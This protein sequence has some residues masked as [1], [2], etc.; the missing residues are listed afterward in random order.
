VTCPPSFDE[1]IKLHKQG[2]KFIAGV[3][4]VGRGALAGPV[5]AAAVILPVPANFS[6]LS[7]VRDSKQISPLKRQTVSRL[8][9]KSEIAI[10]LGMISSTIIDGEGIVKATQLAMSQA[11]KKLPLTPDFILIDAIRLPGVPLPQK[12]I[13]HGDR[14][15]LSIACASIIAK[16][17]R[18][19]YMMRQDTLYPVYGLAGHK[20]YG[21][22]EH[23][24]NLKE[25]GPC[26]I[27]RRSFSPV[28]RS[29]QR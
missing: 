11:I 10:G 6:W 27:H 15:S 7:Q 18:D 28:R 2:Y 5:V 20:G 17:N 14:L 1:E 22:R 19:E 12:S 13:V 8:A 26:P 25:L 16:V 9:Q 3:D 4:E 29:L 23:M 21:T 24:F